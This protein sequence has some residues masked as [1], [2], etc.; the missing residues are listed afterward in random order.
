MPYKDCKEFSK[1]TDWGVRPVLRR[2]PEGPTFREITLQGIKKE[3]TD[4]M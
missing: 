2:G 4:I 3:G 1:R